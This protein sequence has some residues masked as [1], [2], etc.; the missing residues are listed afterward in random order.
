MFDVIEKKYIVMYC[1]SDDDPWH[2][3]FTIT[4]FHC[5]QLMECLLRAGLALWSVWPV[6][7]LSASRQWAIELTSE[8]GISLSP[9]T[10]RKVEK[11]CRELLT[12][13]R[14]TLI[15]LFSG[16]ICHK[17]RKRGTGIKLDPGSV[18]FRLIGQEPIRSPADLMWRRED[19]RWYR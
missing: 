11:R 14:S 13:R 6:C 16:A 12:L 9:L 2:S 18:R 4:K 10:K 17:I 5:L 19:P 8:D 15:C 7:T 3:R 1:C